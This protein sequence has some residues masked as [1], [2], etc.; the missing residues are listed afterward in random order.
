MQLPKESRAVHWR[1][2]QVRGWKIDYITLLPVSE[3]S[4]YTLG[5]VDTAPGL[6]QAFPCRHANQAATIRG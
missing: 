1:S 3:G 6:T 4:K 5:C 2:Q